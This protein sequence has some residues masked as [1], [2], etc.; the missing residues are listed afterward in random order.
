MPKHLT[1]GSVARCALIAA[2]GTWSVS[3]YAQEASPTTQAQPASDAESDR[4]II[5]TGSL[6]RGTPRDAA[7]PVDVL[8]ADALAK[9]GVN[10][11]LELIKQLPTSGAV[12]GDS[13]QFNGAAQSFI[14]SGSVNLRG[15]GSARTL[16]LLNNRR[17]ITTPGTGFTDTN[18]IPYF[19]LDRVEVLKDGAAATYGSDAIAGVV[20][21]ITRDRFEGVEARGEFSFVDGS[22]GDWNASILAGHT[23]GSANL[24]IG[25]SY[26]R[27]SELETRDR[28]YTQ[29]PYGVNPAGFSAIGN[30]GTYQLGTNPSGPY[31]NNPANVAYNPR[32]FLIGNAVVDSNCAGFGGVQAAPGATCFWTYVPYD[33]LVEDENRY[34]AFGRLTVD[35]TEAMRFDLDVLWART[36]LPNVRVS[37]AYLPQQ[38]PRG[39]GTAYGFFVPESN[40][41][42]RSFQAQTGALFPGQASAATPSGIV[43]AGAYLTSARLFGGGGNVIF[44]DDFGPGGQVGRRTND[45]YRISASLRGE[46][47]DSLNFELAGT[48]FRSTRYQQI[49]DV[50]SSRLQ[51]ALEG[52]GGVGCNPVTGTPGVGP[53]R[54][55]NPFSNSMPGNP[56]LGTTNPGYVSATANDPALIAWMFERIGYRAKEDQFVVDAVVSGN[57]FSLPGG[58]AG[59]A[60]GAQ[61]RNVGY[62]AKP[63]NVLENRAQ[64]P[65]PLPG[66]FSCS[67]QTGPL[68]FIG[69]QEH[70]NA[71]QNVRAVFAELNLPIVDSVN[72]QGAV[73]YEDYGGGVGS[74]INPKLTGRWEVADF[75]T[76]RGSVGTTFRGPIPATVAPTRT[77][78]LI[79][80]AAVGNTNR[81]VDNIGNPNLKPEKAFNWS[82]GAIFQT[83]GLTVTA[84]YWSI[85]FEDRIISLTPQ[86][87]ASAVGGTGTGAQLANCASPLR[88][89]VIFGNNNTCTQG[90]TTGNDIARV[91]APYV[92]GPTTNVRGVDITADL[93]V[94][95]GGGT[96]NVGGN[97]SLVLKYTIDAYALGNVPFSGAYD[98]LGYANYDREPGTVSKWRAN[99][100][101]NYAIGPFNARYT[102]T[103]V[104]GVEDNRYAS[105]AFQTT[106]VG[107]TQ[108]GRF[109]RDYVQQ[110]IVVTYDLELG[111]AEV[112]L[113]GG[114]INLFN[115]QPPGARLEYGY[116]PFIG[117]PIGRVFR[118]GAKIGF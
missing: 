95:L 60:V 86:T 53:C 105:A 52:L 62:Q 80:L 15:L 98:A 27:R 74:T 73:R 30:P 40:P 66:D 113:N 59:F 24:M 99:G 49:T 67:A 55:F 87:T 19:A 83:G 22:K 107:T 69:Q 100:F 11:P 106:A 12:I 25:A 44:P 47:T 102:V 35:L 108:F 57:L 45:A 20:N 37:P 77:T 90:V 101:V 36:D 3:A 115:R 16:V 71:S 23:F 46:L 117:N 50:V 32:N 31:R 9:A 58:D 72:V 39:P 94:P 29:R 75:L 85:K 21:F 76:V 48:Y 81:A 112:Q 42:F 54:Y 96:L 110:D 111:G 43:G 2:L 91:Q 118:V 116:D 68:I 56:A 64:N 28:A 5:V 82:A 13:N 84:D 34:Q 10:S 114:V 78:S 1:L 104:D 79:G 17:T 92:N 41:G 65:C 61:Y 103:W 7:L 51:N 33:N 109:V 8:N 26:L 38:G 18:L 93:R 88:Q 6:I 63:L 97:A 70:V 4:D 14:G 89:Y